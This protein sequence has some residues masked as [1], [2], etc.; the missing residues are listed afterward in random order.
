MDNNYNNLLEGRII[1]VNNFSFYNGKLDHAWNTGRICLVLYTS[2]EFEYV[3]PITHRISVLY[4]D[5]YF[6][7]DET[8]IQEYYKNRFRENTITRNKKKGS[9]NSNDIRGYIDLKY[10]Y[11]IPIAYRD[12]IGKITYKTYLNLKKGLE[13]YHKSIDKENDIILCLCK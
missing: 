13:N 6:F 8:N 3:L 10:V 9:K 2:D 11:K 4:K 1:V 5:E 12:E 7:I